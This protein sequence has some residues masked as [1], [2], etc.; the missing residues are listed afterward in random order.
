[1]PFLSNE[2]YAEI[3]NEMKDVFKVLSVKKPGKDEVYSLME[4]LKSLD[5]KKAFTKQIS[6][7]GNLNL[8]SS[9]IQTLS[10]L[11]AW[12]EEY[13]DAPLCEDFICDLLKLILKLNLDLQQII[14]SA[15]AFIL[16]LKKLLTLRTKTLLIRRMLA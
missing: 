16:N 4:G 1:M 14:A 15:K 5:G 7:S 11:S 9:E 3:K 6:M 2:E 10:I 8:V 12:I 13:I